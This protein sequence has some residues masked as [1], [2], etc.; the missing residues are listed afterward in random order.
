MKS[1]T[2]LEEEL[3]RELLEVKSPLFMVPQEIADSNY[4]PSNES[5]LLVNQLIM[6]EL[7][8]DPTNESP[9]SAINNFI[10]H[11]EDFLLARFVLTE[12]RLNKN[13]IWSCINNYHEYVCGN[14]FLIGL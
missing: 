12:W 6:S 9:S 13:L 5:V 8:S 7:R 14:I 1:T 2:W 4:N 3:V 10:N 11:S